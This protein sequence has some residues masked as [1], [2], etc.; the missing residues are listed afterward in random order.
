MVPRYMFTQGQ[1]I[2][3]QIVKKLASNGVILNW[4]SKVGQMKNTGIMSIILIRYTYDK[5][6]EMIQ[7]LVQ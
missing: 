6:L 5:D 4:P 2:V 7:P 3:G 1:N